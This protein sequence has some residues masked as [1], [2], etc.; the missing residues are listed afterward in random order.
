MDKNSFTTPQYKTLINHKEKISKLFLLLVILIIASC[1]SPDTIITGGSG[2]PFAVYKNADGS[3]QIID[4]IQ[5]NDTIIDEVN[6]E[7]IDIRNIFIRNE[8]SQNINKFKYELPF[9]FRDEDKFDNPNIDSEIISCTEKEFLDPKEIC[10]ISIRFQPNAKDNFTGTINISV[11]DYSFELIKL[12]G[13]GLNNTALEIPDR[14]ELK[15]GFIEKNEVFNKKITLT[16]NGKT[17][18]PITFKLILKGNLVESNDI[19]KVVYSPPA[20]RDDNS[21]IL[22]DDDD[23]DDDD[24]DR[25]SDTRDDDDVLKGMLKQGKSCTLNFKI[26]TK[27]NSAHVN[28]FAY[29][30][31][32]LKQDSYT[33]IIYVTGIAIEKNK[34]TEY[35]PTAPNRRSA[36]TLS[37]HDKKLLLIGGAYDRGSLGIQRLDDIWKYNGLSWD[38]ITTK[39][40]GDSL[41][42][43]SDA[44]SVFINNTTFLVGG[45]INAG[46]PTDNVIAL[47]NLNITNPVGSS[48]TFPA[49]HSFAHALLDKYIYLLG[50]TDISNVI[51][52]DTL[53]KFHTINNSFEDVTI[54]NKGD[55]DR[56]LL[57]ASLNDKLYILSDNT[58]DGSDLMRFHV[59]DNSSSNIYRDITAG[60]NIT[61]IFFGQDVS[62]RAPSRIQELDFVVRDNA[63]IV[64]ANNSIFVFGGKT[65]TGATNDMYIYAQANHE[66][67]PININPKIALSKCCSFARDK[68]CSNTCEP[69]S[70]KAF[71]WAQFDNKTDPLPEARYGADMQAIGDNI[72]LFGGIAADNKTMLNDLWKYEVKNY[73]WIKLMDNNDLDSVSHK[74]PPVLVD[75]NKVCTLDTETPSINGF[76]FCYDISINILKFI[77]PNVPLADDVSDGARVIY[78]DRNIYL[79]QASDSGK[80]NVY[81]LD[82]NS[83][84]K[85]AIDPDTDSNIAL[86]GNM[87]LAIDNNTVYSFE[88][89]RNQRISYTYDLT[90]TGTIT[91]RYILDYEPPPPRTNGAMAVFDNHLYIQGGNDEDGKL[92][93]TRRLNLAPPPPGEYARDWE[94]LDDKMVHKAPAYI[95][96]SLVELDN[97]LYLIGGEGNTPADNDKIYVLD[98]S[99]SAGV[100]I[101][102]WVEVG[103]LNIPP[104]AIN[105]DNQFIKLDKNTIIGIDGS[106]IK[107]LQITNP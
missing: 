28:K 40:Q 13:E 80:I 83:W 69:N 91:K 67:I 77:E 6:I 88:H 85:R 98:E 102:G 30:S 99:P 86:Y 7:N 103:P 9:G 95:N 51:D 47:K 64:T 53:K 78:Y 45:R 3:D 55:V 5:F 12:A 70:P 26:T 20:T 18:E 93:D 72:Y 81:N 52:N 76:L 96:H 87:T 54:A 23:D 35:T 32:I 60:D 42:N 22:S 84:Y 29:S 97:K 41:P 61:H 11:P 106:T 46:N 105:G 31:I 68:D 90:G 24:N 74:T 100:N 49:K 58:T 89:Y 50:G 14:G 48:G 1:A 79:F 2:S 33:D 27:N 56:A 73:R 62:V 38:N 92:S 82:N 94:N 34:M 71:A 107:V 10:R 59:L 8:S 75:N 65:S 25:D 17:L 4:L 63:S 37:I 57:M 44:G 43:I 19:L 21:C 101:V 36:P 15:L 39:Y 104:N 66:L 16:H